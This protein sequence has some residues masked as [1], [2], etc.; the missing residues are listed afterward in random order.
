MSWVTLTPGYFFAKPA[1]ILSKTALSSARQWAKETFPETL[2][3]CVGAAPG[4]WPPLL[5]EPPGPAHAPTARPPAATPNICRRRRRLIDPSIASLLIV[6]PRRVEVRFR[7]RRAC[8]RRTGGLSPPS[9]L[10]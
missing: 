9:P 1:I 10:D 5:F 2:P 3:P 4:A 7:T 8:V 6:P